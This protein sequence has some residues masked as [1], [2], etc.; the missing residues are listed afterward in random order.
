MQL[1]GEHLKLL[2]T[3]N[4]L[5]I[6]EFARQCGISQK[7]LKDLELNKRSKPEEWLIKRIASIYANK[8]GW[9]VAEEKSEF[10]PGSETT[11]TG[12][13]QGSEFWEAENY[14]MLKSRNT[15]LEK[16]VER[17]WELVG[18]V[19]SSQSGRFSHHANKDL[20]SG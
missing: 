5:S 19:V 3:R 9:P 10:V 12:E 17:L 18:Y 2:R 7:K 13:E 11:G 14:R 8:P 20:I 6:K 15:L 16:E 4:Q 1:Y